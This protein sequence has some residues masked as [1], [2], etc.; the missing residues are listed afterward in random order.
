[1][2]KYNQFIRLN[3]GNSDTEVYLNQILDKILD[4][5][6]LSKMEQDFLKS[7]HDE[8]EVDFYNKFK[9]K[10]IKSEYLD[11]M[12]NGNMFDII[13]THPKMRNI[14]STKEVEKINDDLF[15]IHSTVDGWQTASLTK[16]QLISLMVGEIDSFSLDWK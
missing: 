2:L 14:Q 9:S 12:E 3:E 5:V 4:K 8:N 11:N 10:I 16:D 13:F 15:Y 6:K 7:F 1:M